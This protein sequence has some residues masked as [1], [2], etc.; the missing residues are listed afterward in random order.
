M[1]VLFGLAVLAIIAWYVYRA[2]KRTG[3]RLG[4]NAGRSRA[5]RFR[6]R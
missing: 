3:S 1:E 2:G 6:R 4:F 5:R